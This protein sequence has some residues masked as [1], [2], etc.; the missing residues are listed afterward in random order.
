MKEYAWQKKMP[1]KH[2]KDKNGLWV[3]WSQ[4]APKYDPLLTNKMRMK[5]RKEERLIRQINAITEAELRAKEVAKKTIKE[6][7]NAK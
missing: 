4:P 7:A 5:M 3:G 6:F 2:H 1:K